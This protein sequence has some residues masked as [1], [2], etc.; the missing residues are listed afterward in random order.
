M[1]TILGCVY[2]LM[3]STAL[4][5]PAAAA[6]RS[7]LAGRAATWE[8]EYNADNLTAVAAL[9]TSDACR[10]PPNQETVTGRDGILQH[11]KLSKEQGWAKA[12]VVVTR[13]GTGGDMGY[14]TGTYVLTRADGSEVDHGK[15]M[16]YSKKVNGKWLIQC[17]MFN[18]DVPMPGGGAK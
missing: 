4:A 5:I 13:A 7:D 6:D 8:K 1:K 18:S 2:I 15:W 12:K 11:L 17:D 16:N 9:Y 3:L 14:G 10:M